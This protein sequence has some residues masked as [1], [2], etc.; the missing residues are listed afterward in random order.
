MTAADGTS[1]KPRCR[2]YLEFTMNSKP[3]SERDKQRRKDDD[4]TWLQKAAQLIDPPGREVSDDELI[5]PGANIP[6]EIP[7][8]G[9]TGRKTPN[10]APDRT[11]KK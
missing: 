7:G 9:D 11:Q 6:N 3:E 5:D 8:R 2:S 10:Q 1:G 4:K